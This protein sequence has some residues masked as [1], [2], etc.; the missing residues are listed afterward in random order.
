MFFSAV[1]VGFKDRLTRPLNASNPQTQTNSRS[2][3]SL[4]FF[5]RIR[6]VARE[7]AQAQHFSICADTIQALFIHLIADACGYCYELHIFHGENQNKKVKVMR[8]SFWKSFSMGY[9]CFAFFLDHVHFTYL[10]MLLLLVTFSVFSNYCNFYFL[11]LALS[12]IEFH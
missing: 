12:I 4:I 10:S 11:F 7:Q 3:L 6:A 9:S 1:V 5:I 8:F 2:Y